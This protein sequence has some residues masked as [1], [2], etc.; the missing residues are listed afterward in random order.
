MKRFEKKL[1][2]TT[3]RNA[4]KIEAAEQ[5]EGTAEKVAA[6]LAAK[7][8]VK[9][10][11]RP[12]SFFAKFKTLAAEALIGVAAIPAAILYGASVV[13]DMM[14]GAGETLETIARS[15]FELR[16]NLIDAKEAKDENRKAL[17]DKC[18]GAL[19][20]VYEQ[21]NSGFTKIAA[22]TKALPSTGELTAAFD[23]TTGQKETIETQFQSI[24][25]GAI[26][27]LKQRR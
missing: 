27:T 19:A 10:S 13:A 21:D 7:K 9:S 12:L 4:D 2:K 14:I 25:S 26:R 5:I 24:K 8:K 6:L 17:L 1:A 11:F 20:A 16:E 22:I 3:L 15:P 18:D 23:F